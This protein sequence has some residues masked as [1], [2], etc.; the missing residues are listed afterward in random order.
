M[1]EGR[2]QGTRGSLR[3]IGDADT[4]RELERNARRSAEHDARVLWNLVGGLDD[5]IIELSDASEWKWA[6]LAIRRH[7]AGS[8]VESSVG[9]VPPPG[10]TQR[11]ASLIAPVE[12]SLLPPT[13]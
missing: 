9:P 13:G 6:L 12:R 7:L 1:S 8:L 4:T 3:L 10:R 11:L 2:E 5:A